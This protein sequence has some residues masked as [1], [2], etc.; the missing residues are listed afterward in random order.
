MRNQLLL[1]GLVFLSAGSAGAEESRHYKW[2]D[3]D[4]KVYYGDSVP[5]EFTDLRKEVVNDHGV[6]IDELAGKKTE[7]ELM[8]E[9]RAE[10]LRQQQELQSRA[11]KALLAT[12]LSVHEIELHRD[13]R[14]ELFKAQYRVTELYLRNLKRRLGK[15]EREA[16]RFQPYSDD[17]EAPMVDPTLVDAIS[18]TESII[19]RHEG[20]LTQFREDERQIIARF[21]GDID[22]FKRLKGVE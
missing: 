10:E 22:R 3:A 4:G 13:R 6:V 20:N 12:Y 21:E 2:V 11:D 17:A 5:P 9:R 7:E 14:V 8:A 18:E 16:S 15:L 1:I 19:A